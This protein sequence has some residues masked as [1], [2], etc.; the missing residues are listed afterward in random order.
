MECDAAQKEVP[1]A[2]PL[3]AKPF[4]HGFQGLRLA[5]LGFA[6]E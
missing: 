6:L 5:L 4:R 3:A 2:P 1:S